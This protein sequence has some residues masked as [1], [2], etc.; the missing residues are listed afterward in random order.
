MKIHATVEYLTLGAGGVNTWES[1][2]RQHP[3]MNTYY[4]RLSTHSPCAAVVL[5]STI[6]GSRSMALLGRV[7]DVWASGN[8]VCRL[9]RS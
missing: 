1:L 5:L 4:V 8:L 6:K 3:S 9:V 7:R 2:F